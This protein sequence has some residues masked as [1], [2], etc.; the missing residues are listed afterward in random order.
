MSNV[1]VLNCKWFL[2]WTCFL[3]L[4]SLS[5]NSDSQLQCKSC[6]AV[7]AD[8]RSVQ[9]AQ[10]QQ[11]LFESPVHDQTTEDLAAAHKGIGSWAP[12]YRAD[13][14]EP[15]VM[16]EELPVSHVDSLDGMQA[17]PVLYLLNESNW[18]WSYGSPEGQACEYVNTTVSPLGH[19]QDMTDGKSGPTEVNH[20][21]DTS[22][23]VENQEFDR[24]N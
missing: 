22:D 12:F 6:I 13:A 14:L 9:T 21:T 23:H 19:A 3:Y 2:L 1:T 11:Q 17:Q 7:A 8:S 15:S 10:S 4:T 16:L 20:T 5:I 24:T 18:S